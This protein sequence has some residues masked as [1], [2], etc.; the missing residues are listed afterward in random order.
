MRP[1]PIAAPTDVARPWR[2]ADFRELLK[3][4]IAAFV[5]VMAAASYLLGSDGTIVW[6]ALV[7]LML[8]TGLTAG[9]A[10]ALNHVA[11]RDHDRKMTRTRER[12]VTSGRVSPLAATLYGLALSAAGAV[13]LA[14][15]T[16]PITTGL[17]ILTIALY[18]VVYTPLKR[19]TV[20][21]TLVGAV[22]GALPALGGVT[23]ATGALDATGWALFAVLYLWQ[24]PHFYALAWMLRDDYR[25]GGFAMLPNRPRG[26]RAMARIS[27]G[28]T[29]LLMVA[30]MLPGALG[31][32]GMV[33][34]VGAAF[35]GLAFTIPA[36]SF[37][38]A[39]SDERARRLFLASVFWV[40]G[41]FG[42][43]MLDV[44]LR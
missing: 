11:E 39:P 6:R 19:R 32:A 9:G 1:S 24:L 8:G 23:A 36:F 44:L 40:P 38:A 5:V 28:A 2:L 13:V 21:N 31:A 15:T 7:G 16:N 22:P 3:P 26:K 37:N 12:P 10:G 33:Y 25:A 35:L 27:L 41:F 42:L 4:G 18:V 30:A 14:L 29:L 17:A 34:L 43:V 20:H